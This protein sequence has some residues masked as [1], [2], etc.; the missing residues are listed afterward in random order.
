M[1]I[2]GTIPL[3]DEPASR[4]AMRY[5][6]KGDCEMVVQDIQ[7]E[8]MLAVYVNDVLTMQVA[9]SPSHL[10]ELVL[11]RL[12]TEGIIVSTDE[13]DALSVCE[14]SMRADVVLSAKVRPLTR[15]LTWQH[16]CILR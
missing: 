2:I 5:D 9:C 3:I 11:G 14:Q 7:N 10:D 1:E 15:Q 6:R 13:V 16:R 12:C 4:R 8:T